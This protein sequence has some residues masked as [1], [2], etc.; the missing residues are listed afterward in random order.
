LIGTLGAVDPYL[1]KQIKQSS[2]IHS[3]DVPELPALL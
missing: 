1:V 3:H 2:E